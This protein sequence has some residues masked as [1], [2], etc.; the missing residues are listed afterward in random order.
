MRSIKLL[1]ILS[2]FLISSSLTAQWARTYGTLSYDIPRSIIKAIDEGYIIVGNSGPTGSYYQSIGSL[3]IMKISED[4]TI[5]WQQT[6]KSTGDRTSAGAYDIRIT[7]DR[8]YIMVGRFEDKDVPLLVLKL[9]ENGDIEWHKEYGGNGYDI[10][11][12]VLET[13]DNGYMV[14][15]TTLSFGAGGMDAWILKLDSQGDIEWQK[16]YGESGNDEISS[17][18]PVDNNKYIVLGNAASFGQGGFDI[19]LF[20]ISNLGDVIWQKTYG[21]AGDDKA[22]TLEN[23][24]DDGYIVGGESSSFGAGGMDAWILKLDSQGNIE[25]Q[26]TYGGPGD[27]GIKDIVKNNNHGYSVV[28]STQKGNNLDFLIMKIGLTG[29]IVQQWSFGGK[30]QDI[31]YSQCLSN[32][33]LYFITGSTRSFGYKTDEVLIIMLKD[34]KG[35][36]NCVYTGTTNLIVSN[37]NIVPTESY[38]VINITSAAHDIYDIAQGLTFVPIQQLCLPSKKK[39]KGVIR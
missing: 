9:T 11:L 18:Q 5:L 38:A 29:E 30:N 20:E 28:G 19:W 10:G 3:W 37:T 13:N 25:W 12:S 17:I 1:I 39:G 22:F 32:D 36:E 27:D 31:A 14:A 24:D 2:I 16:T 34:D 23:T 7:K 6:I 35:I 21:G 26:K 15:G 4:G 33:G 8:G